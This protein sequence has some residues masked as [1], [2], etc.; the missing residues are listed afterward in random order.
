MV[1]ALCDTIENWVLVC[2]DT[3]YWEMLANNQRFR[4]FEEWE[5]PSKWLSEKSNIVSLDN[6]DLAFELEQLLDGK[7]DFIVPSSLSIFA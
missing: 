5:A 3:C 7:Q 1:I 4:L 6:I 2:K